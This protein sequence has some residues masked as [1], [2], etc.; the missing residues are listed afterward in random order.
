ML[1]PC[2]SGVWLQGNPWITID[3]GLE[4]SEILWI[5]LKCNNLVKMIASGAAKFGNGVAI[6][7]AAINED[8]VPAE[9]EKIVGKVLNSRIDPLTGEVP[10]P[11]SHLTVELLTPRGIQ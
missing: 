5:G 11:E 8:L 9:L 4:R 10:Q 2:V 3:G 1:A 7:G 6:V